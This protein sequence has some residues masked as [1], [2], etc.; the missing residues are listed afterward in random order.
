MNTLFPSDGKIVRVCFVFPSAN[1]ET[2]KLLRFT[3]VYANL[4][5]N[6]SAQKF[7]LNKSERTHTHTK[8]TIQNCRAII[9]VQKCTCELAN[10]N[11]AKRIAEKMN[12]FRP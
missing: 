8:H 11:N 12:F 2:P 1:N 10:E 3:R 4:F 7:Q 6:L 9:S 5:S